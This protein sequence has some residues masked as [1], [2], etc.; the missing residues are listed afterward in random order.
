MANFDWK[1]IALYGVLAYFAYQNKDR[2][3][4]LFEKK[5]AEYTQYEVGGI[6]VHDYGSLETPVSNQYGGMG[7]AAGQNAS[8]ANEAQLAMTV[9]GVGQNFN[10]RA[11]GL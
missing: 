1:S 4:G 2:L 5:D 7:R 11:F 3:M 8:Q 10:G 6:T 9:G